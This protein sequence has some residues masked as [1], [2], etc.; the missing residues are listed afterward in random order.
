LSKPDFFRCRL[1]AM[2]DVRHPLVLLSAR[3]P[4]DRIE[5][6]P[7]L[8]AAKRAGMALEQT[9]PRKARSCGARPAATRMP[10]SFGA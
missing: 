6:A 10:S 9:L 4:W 1:D 7:A 2:I 5:Q 8:S 3:L